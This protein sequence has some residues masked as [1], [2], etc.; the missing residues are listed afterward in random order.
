MIPKIIHYCW[1]GRES[2]P[3][4]VDHCLESWHT[5]MPDW[6]YCEWNENNFN[7]SS[8]PLYVQQAY[9]AKKYAFV[10]DY[11]RLWALE[12]YGGLYMDVDFEVYKPFDELMEQYSAFAGIEGS[13]YN[14]VMMGVCASIAHGEW[15]TQMLHTYDNRPFVMPDGTLDMTPNTSYLSDVMTA[16]GFLRNGKEQDYMDLHVFT[17]DYF[18]PRL[19]T[20]EFIQTDSTYCSTCGLNSWAGEG[21]WKSKLINHLPLSWKIVL[22][23]LKRRIF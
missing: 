11:V 3:Q 23:K 17:A 10:S 12:L 2:K 8:A 18:S 1:F 13:R 9:E 19:T 6:K 4:M 22:I 16:N 21:G 15:V 20:G 14:P 7:L 5:H